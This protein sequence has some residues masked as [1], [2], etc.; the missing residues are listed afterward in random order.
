ADAQRNPILRPNVE[1]DN[2]SFGD[3]TQRQS[4]RSTYSVQW[5]ALA[6]LNLQ[7]SLRNRVAFTSIFT[8]N[9]DDEARVF[10]GCNYGN[11]REVS[12]SRLRFIARSMLFSQLSGSSLISTRL[13]D[14]TLDWN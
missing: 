12:Y 4:W 10:Q 9:S 13:G 2:G 5:A 6:S 14:S 1:Y 7:A 11:D 3:G 8:Q